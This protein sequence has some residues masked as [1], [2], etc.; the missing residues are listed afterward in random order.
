MGDFLSYV[1]RNYGCVAEYNRSMQDDYEHECEL[2]AKR[3][4]YYATNK[5]KLDKASKEGTLVY[6]ADDCIGCPW[7]TEI[8]MTGN[9]DDI[10]HGICGNLEI[11]D[12]DYRKKYE[13]E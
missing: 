10:E 13:V 3:Y 1:E 12:C 6:F 9:E 5:A 2:E 8:G 11:K 7:Y 4:E